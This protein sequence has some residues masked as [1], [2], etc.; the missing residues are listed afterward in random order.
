MID[1]DIIIAVI[2]GLINLVLSSIVPCMLKNNKESM[3][4]NIKKIFETNKNSLIISSL[5]IMITTY[6]A[7]KISANIDLSDLTLS[8]NNYNNFDDNKMI[9]FRLNT[10]NNDIR[11][12]ANFPKFN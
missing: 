9:V 6:I 3:L 1:N 8:D 5:I 12:F 2:S 7:C 10:G 11:N 4:V